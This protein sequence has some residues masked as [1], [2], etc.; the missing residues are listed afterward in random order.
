MFGKLPLIVAIVLAGCSAEPD[1]SIS[2]RPDSGTEEPRGVS[3]NN[4]FV[5]CPDGYHDAVGLDGPECTVGKNGCIEALDGSCSEPGVCICDTNCRDFP[6]DSC[7]GHADCEPIEVC[8][9][10]VP[11]AAC[12]EEPTCGD[13]EV[14]LT[15]PCVVVGSC[16]EAACE[17]DPELI[18]YCYPADS[19]CSET[20]CPSGSLECAALSETCLETE[21]CGQIRL[22]E[23]A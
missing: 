12:P 7:D 23:T 10:S 1:E 21:T 20:P 11:C 8:G 18:Y 4:A 16:R 13:R 14:L 2:D 19:S 17:S 6:V 22:C 3:C 9:E 5:M 15:D